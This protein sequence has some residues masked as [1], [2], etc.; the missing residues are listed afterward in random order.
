LSLFFKYKKEMNHIVKMVDKVQKTKIVKVIGKISALIFIILFLVNLWL[1]GKNSM[2]QS[3]TWIFGC[4]TIVW[5]L[6]IT[7]AKK[8]KKQTQN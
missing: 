4:I 7:N 2:V 3:T 8:F 5:V 1:N 6:W